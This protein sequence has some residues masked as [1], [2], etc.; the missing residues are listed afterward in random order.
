MDQKYWLSKYKVFKNFNSMDYR[1]DLIEGSL[2]CTG[3][4]QHTDMVVGGSGGDHQPCIRNDTGQSARYKMLAWKV[5]PVIH[6]QGAACLPRN[7]EGA[8]RSLAAC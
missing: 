1:E 6:V 3:N 4:V 5:L 8:S 2:Y 7:R